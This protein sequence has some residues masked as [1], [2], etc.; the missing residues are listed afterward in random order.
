MAVLRV[1]RSF[2]HDDRHYPKGMEV[3]SSDPVTKGREDNFVVVIP[4]PPK[5]K[6]KPKEA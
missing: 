3:D 5:P 6:P 1:L 4:D 2:N